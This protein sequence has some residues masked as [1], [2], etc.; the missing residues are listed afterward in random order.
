MN[1]KLARPR[2]LLLALFCGLGLA[3]AALAHDAPEEGIGIVMRQALPDAGK[4]VTMLTVSYQPGGVAKPH[5]HPGAVFAY[6][7]EG[8]VVSQLGDGEAKTYVQGQSWYEPPGT[9]HMVS[10]NASATQ[11]AKLLVWALNDPGQPVKLPLPH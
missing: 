10:R 5:L 7:L 1:S 4:Q 2:K 8:S 3:G 9:H 6:V 11:P